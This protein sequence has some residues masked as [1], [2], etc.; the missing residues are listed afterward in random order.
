MYISKR[1]N[2][3]TIAEFKDSKAVPFLGHNWSKLWDQMNTANNCLDPNDTGR[4][5]TVHC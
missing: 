3:E 5:V 2:I 1:I 4:P